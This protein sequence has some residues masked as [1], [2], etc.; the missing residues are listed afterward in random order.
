MKKVVF[1]VFGIS[2]GVFLIFVLGGKLFTG[3]F[4]DEKID[5]LVDS[6]Q[7]REVVFDSTI[8]KT[9]PGVLRYY[10]EEA[11][12]PGTKLP[13][14]VE[15]RHEG[16]FRTSENAS[17]QK[18]T[19]HQY[20]SAANPGFVWDGEIKYF[21]GVTMRGIDSYVNGQGNMLIK[22]LSSITISDAYGEE[23]D[24]SSLCRYAVEMVL[25]PTSMLP[26][27]HVS[28]QQTGPF[29]A[30]MTLTDKKNTI[31][32]IFF[33]NEEGLIYKVFTEDRFLTSNAGYVKTPYT[34]LFEEYKK[35]DGRN[36][37]T[38]IRVMWNEKGGDFEYGQFRITK[39]S[40]YD[41]PEK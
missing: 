12:K 20:Y 28:W 17:W 5:E 19:G 38:Y 13:Q 9:L 8:A 6:A 24:V 33:F 30:E 18:I 4:L 22:L 25:F 26:S 39:V 7:K 21:P 40:Y 32:L 41:K 15:T 27:E 36:I 16:L 11:V 10:F 1:T 34:V 37:P 2:L 31:K 29:K 35:F 23:M 14:L 3:Q